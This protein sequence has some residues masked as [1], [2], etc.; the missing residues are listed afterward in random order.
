MIAVSQTPG[1]ERDQE[2]HFPS[3]SSL[4]FKKLSFQFLKLI[5]ILAH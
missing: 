5:I 3:Y 2:K 1:P 4:R